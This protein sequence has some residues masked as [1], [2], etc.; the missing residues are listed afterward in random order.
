[1][2]VSA[3]SYGHI[4]SSSTPLTLTVSPGGVSSSGNGFSAC[5]NP[6]NTGIATGS[7]SGGT[8]SY[9]YSWARVGAASGSGGF[10]ANSST[11]TASSFRDSNNNVCDG[12]SPSSETWRLTVDDGVDT[13]TDD[14]TVTI[15]WIDL[16]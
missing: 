3:S 7:A 5:G 8:G 10:T 9:T 12:D 11:S 1:V 2:S 6:G 14:V 16:S 4:Y 13:A 15:T